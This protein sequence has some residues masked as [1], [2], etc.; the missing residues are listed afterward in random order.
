MTLAES[1]VPRSAFHLSR[2]GLPLF[3]LA[4]GL[5]CTVLA[6]FQIKSSVD[7]AEGLR[8]E[9]LASERVDVVSDRL[10]TYVALLRGTAGLFAA[11]ADVKSDQFA[12][13]IERLRLPELYSGIQGIG[14]IRAIP[15]D[16]RDEILAAI[17]ADGR[18]DFSIKP[19]GARDFQTG[20]AFLEPWDARNAAAYGFDMYTQPVRKAAMDSARDTGLRAVTNKVILGLKATDQEAGFLIFL[21]VYDTPLGRIPPTVE[22][23]RSLLKGWVFS[24]FRSS[25]LFARALDR[26]RTPELDIA[27]YDEADLSE[28]GLLFRSGGAQQ[29]SDSRYSTTR[30]LSI[31][32]HDWTIVLQNTDAFLPDANRIFMP[33]VAA[34]GL[35]ATLLLFAAAV[36]QARVTA[37]AED[38]REKLREMNLSLEDRVEERTA[39]LESARGAL[40][41][42]NR[43]LETI[44]D[45]RTSDLKAANEEIQRFAYIVSHDLRSPLVN[46]MGFTSELQVARDAISKFYEGVIAKLPDVADAKTKAAIE[47]D[48]PEAI[49]FI[50]S[51]TAKMD[52]LI[53]AILRLSR[54]GGRILTPEPIQLKALL[55][56][57]AQSLS[58]QLTD[59]GAELV[60]E[61]VPAIVGDRLALEQ[62]FTNLLENAVKYL[63]PGRPGRIRVHGWQE[64]STVFIDVE[65]NGRGIDPKDHSRVFDL[66]RRA[67]AQD[68]PGEGIGLAHVRALVRRLGGTISLHS[69]AGSGSTFRVSLPSVMTRISEGEVKDA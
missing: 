12:A 18:P 50:R 3:V 42:L 20:I 17:R 54:E 22:E 16:R 36:M 2:L 34:G 63:A 32:D 14:F 67:G 65:D 45:T 52:R 44:V 60:I 19:E 25:N 64:G 11:A 6:V 59:A 38:A 40:E 66:F 26:G 68:R 47:E 51:S 28:E 56:V 39:Q 13:Y 1:S 55:D 49:G 24:P 35:L 53:N 58:H 69:E 10:D 5:V 43:N 29:H 48:L 31:G 61:D 33:I 15:A 27:V 41:A 23:R 7:R 4:A 8:F 57:T 62:I 9:A 37:T 46:V 30:K 21:P